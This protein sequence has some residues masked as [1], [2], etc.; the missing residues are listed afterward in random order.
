MTHAALAP[1]QPITT[2]AISPPLAPTKFLKKKIGSRFSF[3]IVYSNTR[4]L[5]APLAPTFQVCSIKRPKHVQK[6]L[7]A[8]KVTLEMALTSPYWSL[9]TYISVLVCLKRPKHVENVLCVRHATPEMALTSP[10]WSL[11]TYISLFVCIKR[12]Q[13]VQKVLCACKITL[14]MAL[15]S[16]YWSLCTY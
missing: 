10:Y 9:C 7:C 13:H 5:P 6:V 8:C 12:P 4:Y 16:P 14:E 11:C 3:F 15:T 2:R 1:P